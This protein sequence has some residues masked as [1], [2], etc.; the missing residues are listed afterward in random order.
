M[1]ACGKIP[2]DPNAVFELDTAVPDSGIFERTDTVRPHAVALNVA[3]DSIAATIT[4]SVLDTAILQMLDSTTG[5]TV[6]RAVGV[7]RLEARAGTLRSNPI[8]ITV[9]ARADTLFADSTP[10]RDSVSLAAKGDSLSDS[11]RVRLQ[12]FNDTGPP[13]P[14]SGRR[15]AFAFVVGD[16]SFVLAPAADTVVTDANGL[17]VVQVRV[18][19]SATLPDSV[20]LQAS[21]RRLNGAAVAGSPVSF[22]VV[23]AP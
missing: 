12:S 7:G 15:V 16:S 14:L 19:G 4:W 18:R 3:G 10:A 23:F 21:A 6:A 20:V 13:S 17:A 22:T 2:S 1:L 8:A 11:L 9:L 5:E